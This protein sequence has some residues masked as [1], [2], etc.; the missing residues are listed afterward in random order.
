MFFCDI[1]ISSAKK[2]IYNE[3]TKKRKRKKNLCESFSASFH[4]FRIC[5]LRQRGLGCCGSLLLYVTW[6]CFRLNRRLVFLYKC[7]KQLYCC[8]W[9]S[10][11][12]HRFQS[13]SIALKVG[14]YMTMFLL[15][16]NPLCYF[17]CQHLYI[18][19]SKMQRQKL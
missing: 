10:A 11:S 3:L 12:L 18:G 16:R 14:N 7:E 4:L 5:S 1:L 13:F 17:H 2:H 8:G 15:D 9:H 19:V 6:M